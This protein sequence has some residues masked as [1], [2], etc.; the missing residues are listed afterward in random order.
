M[1]EEPLIPEEPLAP[2]LQLS[3]IELW[4]PIIV[5]GEKYALD[6]SLD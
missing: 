6:W 5:P 1:L 2:E 3:F 4:S